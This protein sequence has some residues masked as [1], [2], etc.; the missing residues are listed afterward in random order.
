MEGTVCRKPSV[1]C[2]A[3]NQRKLIPL[4]DQVI[5]DH[6]AGNHIIGLYRSL[7]TIL[8]DSSPLIS[9]KGSGRTTLL[10]RFNLS[11]ITIPCALE[12]PRSGKG[13]ACVDLFCFIGA[14]FGG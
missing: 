9:T 10:L 5:Y 1:K 12:L 11:G 8:V 2:S 3:W 4:T 7:T 6:L 14:G 13:G